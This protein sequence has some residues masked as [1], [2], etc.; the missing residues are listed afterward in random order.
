MTDWTFREH[1]FWS[2][3]IVALAIAWLIWLPAPEAKAQ[4]QGPGQ[5]IVVD[6]DT[7]KSPA[8]VSYRIIG[9]DTPETFQARSECERR[10]GLNA[11]AQLEKLLASG[12]VTVEERGLDKYRRTLAVVRVNGQDVSELMIAQGYARKYDGKSKRQA[13]C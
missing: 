4:I 8:G 6:G 2:C 12:R 11:K 13:W 5:Y 3:V 1:H 9:M 7:I 10:L